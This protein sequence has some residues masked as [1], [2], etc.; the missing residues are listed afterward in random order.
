M[1]LLDH[2]NQFPGIFRGPDI[3]VVI[4]IGVNLAFA[5]ECG[6]AMLGPRLQ[7]LPAIVVSDPFCRPWNRK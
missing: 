2:G 5:V 1:P 7:F 6:S 3:P 4:E